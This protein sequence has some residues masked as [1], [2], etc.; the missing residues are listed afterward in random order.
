MLGIL[1]RLFFPLELAAG[2][3]TKL[4]DIRYIFPRKSPLSDSGIIFVP[5]I[6]LNYSVLISK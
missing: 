5:M 6:E 3:L 4:S 2:L 1:H